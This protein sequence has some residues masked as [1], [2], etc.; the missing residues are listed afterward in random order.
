MIRIQ[1]L[2]EKSKNTIVR[3]SFRYANFPNLSE[4]FYYKGTT[5]ETIAENDLTLIASISFTSQNDISGNDFKFQRYT[6]ENVK[7]KN[8]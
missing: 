6:S 7:K 2:L 4:L 5:K 3:S 1:L 8:R